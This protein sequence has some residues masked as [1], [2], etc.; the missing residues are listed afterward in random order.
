MREYV[1]DNQEAV[2]HASEMAGEY[3]ASIGKSDLS[4]FTGEEWFTLIEVIVSGFDDK[5]IPF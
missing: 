1:K 5:A 2:Q 4:Q 3:L